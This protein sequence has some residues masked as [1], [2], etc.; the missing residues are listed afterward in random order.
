M[1]KRIK[2]YLVLFP[3]LLSRGTTMKWLDILRAVLGGVSPEMRKMLTES[4]DKMEAKAKETKLP[5][6]DIAVMVLRAATGL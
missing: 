5:F 6:D 2:A 4:L 3:L 1:I